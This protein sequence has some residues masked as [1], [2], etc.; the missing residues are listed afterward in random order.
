MIPGLL[1]AL[2][3]LLLIYRMWPRTFRPCM[4]QPA[5]WPLVSII[6]PARNEEK[7]IGPLL[8][9]L[10]K[11][12]YPHYE[13]IVVDDCSDDDTAV[14]ART[15][16]VRL[17]RGKE[18]PEGWNGKQWA[19]HQGAMAA[20]GSYLLFTD[21]DTV[22]HTTGLRR[23]LCEM[24]SSVLEGLTVL[25]QPQDRKSREPPTGRFVFFLLASTHP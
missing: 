21:A 3:L 15:Y 22:H 19:C 24:L 6:V 20:H 23:V 12:D 2:G 25:P 8:D 18:R 9:S 7:V 4:V 5:S 17:L 10:T 1:G 14:I 16:N 11:L 13:I